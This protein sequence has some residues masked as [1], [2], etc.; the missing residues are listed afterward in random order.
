[1]PQ[2][3]PSRLPN[4]RSMRSATSGGKGAAP[5]LGTRSELKSRCLDAGEC[6][7]RD[8][9]GRHAGE[10]GRALVL[11]VAHRLRGVEALAQQDEVAG[12]E[13][14]QQHAGQAIDVKERQDADDALLARAIE[15]APARP[16]IVDRHRGG[17][18]GVRQE[19]ALG[20]AGRAAGI[21]DE[22]DIV[23][24]DLGHRR[25]RR[26]IAEEIAE[27]HDARVAAFDWP[28]RAERHLVA[29][30]D[31]VDEAALEETP[32]HRRKPAGI[33]RDETARAAVGELHRQR[34]L[35]VERRE[36]HDRRPRLGR[37]EERHGIVRRVGKIKRHARARADAV[38]QE[39]CRRA[40]RPCRRARHKRSRG[41]ETRS[42]G[43][44]RT[45]RRGR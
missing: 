31:A 15:V 30:D 36:R 40:V 13:L 34:A 8:P 16:R 5:E 9:H 19:R 43:A 20:R 28:G 14:A 42:R 21:L 2:P 27:R 33:G 22:G 17:E 39:P 24:A 35:G 25:R 11:D 1:M 18:V 45:K 3:P 4:R 38:P 26:I 6:R 44:R 29:H 37:G 10:H 32:R 23:L 12:S 7:E 41:R